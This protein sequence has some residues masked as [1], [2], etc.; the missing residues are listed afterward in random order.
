VAYL[1]L[2]EKTKIILDKNHKDQQG[3]V[4]QQDQ[5]DNKLKKHEKIS[6]TNNKKQL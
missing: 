3:L 2:V 4:D 1:Q 6:F 5:K